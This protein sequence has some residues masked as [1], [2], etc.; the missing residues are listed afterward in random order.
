M[1]SEHLQYLHCISVVRQ[2]YR[3]PLTEYFHLQTDKS[4]GKSTKGPLYR[5]DPSCL[6]L[7]IM[8][9]HLVQSLQPGVQKAVSNVHSLQSGVHQVKCLVGSPQTNKEA[10]GSNYDGSGL[11]VKWI[12][13]R[14]QFSER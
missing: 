4:V 12:P 1:Q 10:N 7:S 14:G 2:I 8:F 9:C 11:E 3:N 6:F 13:E 5:E